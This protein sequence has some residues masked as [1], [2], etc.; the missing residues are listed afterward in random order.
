MKSI[1]STKK[2]LIIA[3]FIISTIGIGVTTIS[4]N[5]CVIGCSTCLCTGKQTQYNLTFTE[6]GLPS[7]QSWSITVNSVSYSS[8][9]STIQ[10][11]GIQPDSTMTYSIPTITINGVIYGPSPSSGSVY[12]S[13]NEGVSVT[14]SAE[15]PPTVTISSPSSNAL[16][17][18]S[19]V[20]SGEATG[21]PSGIKDLKIFVDSQLIS[22]TGSATFSVTC[23]S[24]N[25]NTDNWIP[26]SS[27]TILV[28][29]YPNIGTVGTA[30]I[31]V[32]SALVADYN[33]FYNVVY[34]GMTVGQINYYVGL[35]KANSVDNEVS[36]KM[37][38]TINDPGTGNNAFSCPAIS[39]G[40]Y[41]LGTLYGNTPEYYWLIDNSS[42]S[43]SSFPVYN[44]TYSGTTFDSVTVPQYTL[45]NGSS[46]VSLSIAF[47]DMSTG[48]IEVGAGAPSCGTYTI[49]PNT[50]LSYTLYFHPN[51]DLTTFPSDSNDIISYPVF[52][53]MW[54]MTYSPGFIVGNYT[55][56][57]EMYNN[58]PTDWGVS[59]N[60]AGYYN[61]TTQQ[62]A[63]TL[64][65]TTQISI[66]VFNDIYS[67]CQDGAEP[68]SLLTD[69]LNNLVENLNY[70]YS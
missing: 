63:Q 67:A 31:S 54:M 6:S 3:I 68:S 26:G 69:F 2:M 64:S 16:V 13:N 30:S 39:L 17:P 8:T 37:S 4:G 15:P 19:F 7:G 46:I 60:Q 51:K 11:T 9:T 49:P 12:M 47:K 21:N 1:K 10:I 5:A 55:Y 41:A 20:I 34:S 52:F 18:S 33:A 56:I 44:F 45:F 27:H 23:N 38:L 29:A 59:L 32:T 42:S 24:G 36:M 61:A 70:E 58:G 62:G 48:Q 43:L 57:N 66:N 40:S 28:L 14:F 50:A 22:T 35:Y 65:Y 53:P 25:C